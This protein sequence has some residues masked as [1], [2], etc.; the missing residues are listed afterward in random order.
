M[1][2]GPSTRVRIDGNRLEVAAESRHVANW[3]HSHF[4][5][6]LRDAAKKALGEAAVV[7]VRVVEE[8]AHGG[9]AAGANGGPGAKRTNGATALAEPPAPRRGGAPRPGAPRGSTAARRPDLHL[10]LRHRFEDFVTGASNQLAHSA[11]VR[12]A[13][14]D[15]PRALGPVFIHGECGLGKTHLLQACCRRHLERF[16]GA[17]VRYVTGEQFTNEYIVALKSNKLESFRQKARSLDLLAIDDIHFL[18]NKTSTQNEFLHTL[19]AIDLGGARIV[20]ASDEH[21]RHLRSVSRALVSRF[22][23]GMVVEIERPSRQL[24]IELVRRLAERRG[25]RVNAQAIEL[26]AANCVASVRE[27]EGALNKLVAMTQFAGEGGG[28]DGEVGC[29]LVERLFKIESQNGKPLRIGEIIDVVCRR[30]AVERTDLLTTT[31]HRRVVL[32]RGLVSHLGRELTT[33]SYPEIGRAL[34]RRN[35]STVLTAGRRLAEQVEINEA[36]ELE[37]GNPPIAL[38]ELVDQLRH[39]I[40]RLHRV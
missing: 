20:M 38:R 10:P 18:S 33:L 36:I 9:R 4:G 29:V 16:P 14:D 26:I 32:A 19:D 28:P 40:R 15:N 2:F 25:L 8:A 22:L 12:V 30:L 6:D 3:I 21:P 23:A 1:W 31:R 27:I 34:G 7:D 17:L 39:E 24:R 5:D 35:H 11:A 13:E 37:D